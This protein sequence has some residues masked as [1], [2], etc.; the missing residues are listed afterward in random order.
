MTSSPTLMRMRISG[1][2]LLRVPLSQGRNRPLKRK[3]RGGRLLQRNMQRSLQLMN[4]MKTKSPNRNRR[5]SECINRHLFL[6][7]ETIN[8]SYFFSWAAKAAKIAAGPSAPG[9]KPVPAAKDPN[10]L[11]GLTFVFTGELSAFSREEAIELA[12]RYGG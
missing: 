9:S 3:L 11:A 8:T 5:S 7:P 4:L 2:N 12:K 1:L 10:C 6:F